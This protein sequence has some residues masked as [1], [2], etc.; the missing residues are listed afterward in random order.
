MHL[1]AKDP[2]WH[3]PGFVLRSECAEVVGDDL[4]LKADLRLSLVVWY[5]V[6]IELK[7]ELPIEL[8]IFKVLQGSNTPA[9]NKRH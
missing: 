9:A 6:K 5:E 8:E 4:L 1:G 7:I 2:S 3:A